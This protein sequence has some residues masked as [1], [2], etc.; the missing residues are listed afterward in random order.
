MDVTQRPFDWR[1]EQLEPWLATL[2]G[3]LPSAAIAVLVLAIAHQVATLT[4][5]L[6]PSLAAVLP[7]ASREATSLTEP[8]DF[9]SLLG[10]SLSGE[11]PDRPTPAAS[12]VA[13]DAPDTTLDLVLTGIL[14][15]E[16]EPPQGTATIAD[17]RGESRNYVVGQT[18]EGGEGA[19]VRLVYADRVLIESDGRLETL[20][21]RETNQPGRVD[22]SGQ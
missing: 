3:H 17:R 20:R 11:A 18:I 4:W 15:E 2:N 1:G 6:A 16:G 7:S 21:M 5:T 22:E 13:I 12:A 9:T 8:A 14:A 19:T 10:A